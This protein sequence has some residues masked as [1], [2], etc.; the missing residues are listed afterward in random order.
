MLQ[1]GIFLI[2]CIG[3]VIKLIN[4]SNKNNHPNFSVEMVI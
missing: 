2:A 3:L 4:L 1:F